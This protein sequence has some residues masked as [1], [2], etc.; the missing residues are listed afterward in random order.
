VG[1]DIFWVV[2]W[3][4]LGDGLCVFS[5][6][7]QSFPFVRWTTILWFGEFRRC[8]KKLRWAE[9][10]FLCRCRREGLLLLPCSILVFAQQ[11]APSHC[12]LLNPKM[13]N[14]YVFLYQQLSFH[15]LPPGSRQLS[16]VPVFPTPHSHHW[17]VFLP[18]QSCSFHLEGSPPRSLHG[19][20]LP[21]LGGQKNLTWT[22]R[23][24]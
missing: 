8:C 24:S 2:Y 3:Q 17:K 12:C 18:L 5:L 1:W 22:E 10:N 4:G 23:P 13:Q 20:L 7:W 11:P 19:W 14:P 15:N 16:L 6:P 9:I 21:L